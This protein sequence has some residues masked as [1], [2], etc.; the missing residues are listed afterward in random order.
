M[1]L[2]DILKSEFSDEFISLIQ[3]AVIP[4]ALAMGI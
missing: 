3:S 1:A 4:L 2:E